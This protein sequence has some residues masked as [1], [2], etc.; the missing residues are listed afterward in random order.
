VSDLPADELDG[1]LADLIRREILRVRTD[2]LSPDRGQYA[3]TQTLLRQVAYDT[4]S[5]RDRKMRHLAVA[6]HLRRTF[7]DDGAEVSEV[8]AQHYLDAYNAV[9]DDPDADECRAKASATFARAGHRARGVGA[10]EAALA[11]FDTAAELAND[12][13]LRPVLVEQAGEAALLLGRYDAALDRFEAVAAARSAAGDVLGAAG[14]A[15][16]ISIALAGLRRH[17]ESV[18][19]LRQALEVLEPAGPSAALAKVHARLANALLFL[20]H[21]SEAAPHVEAALELGE[22]LEL[23][24]VLSNAANSRSTLLQFA[25]RPKESL[26]QLEWAG[27]LAEEHSLGREGMLAHVNASDLCLN[28]DQAATENHCQAGLEFARRLGERTVETLVAGNLAHRYLLTGRWDEVERLCRESLDDPDRPGHENLNAR[29]AGLYVLRGQVGPARDE[30]A[31]LAGWA[32]SA[33][34]QSHNIHAYVA[35]AVALAAGDYTDALDLAEPAA[36]ELAETMGLR[37]DMFREAWVDAMEA[38]LVIGPLEKAESLLALVADLPVGHIPRYL[39][40][41]LARFSARLAAAQG[42]D[43]H[44]EAGFTDAEDVFRELGYPYWLAMAQL[45]HAAWLA[46]Q[47]RSADGAALLTEASAAFER[48]GATPALLRAQELMSGITHVAELAPHS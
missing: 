5:R 46:G 36:R 11:A 7:A 41:Q 17:D 33:D 48:L 1:L 45:D 20:G 32:E 30:L 18:H 23:P 26:L 31:A 38:V 22:A 3:F 6:E 13:D 29:L 16:R 35:A 28:D 9:P 10:P 21:R 47:D 37:N 14:L 25:A 19:L 2:R 40:A 44:V 12:D 43:D 4:L 39:R 15:H 24:D 27:A 8:V 42:R 34:V